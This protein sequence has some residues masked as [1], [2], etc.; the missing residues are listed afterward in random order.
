MVS[1]AGK[2]VVPKTPQ[3][4]KAVKAVVDNAVKTTACE[5]SSLV[6][7]FHRLGDEEEVFP[8][9]NII[10]ETNIRS[11]ASLRE[12]ARALG[13][14]EYNVANWSLKDL[15]EFVTTVKVFS[16][17]A[18]EIQNTEEEALTRDDI[19]ALQ[20]YASHD[21]QLWKWATQQPD[22][23]S[24]NYFPMNYHERF[25]PDV[26]SLRI[27][28]ISN[29]FDIIARVRAA[30]NARKNIYVD[31]EAHIGL[32]IKQLENPQNSYDIIV[33]DFSISGGSR[34]RG[35]YEV[36]MYV[37]NKKLDIPVVLLSKG[38]IASSHLILHNIIGQSP[39]LQSVNDAQR[40]FNYLSNIVATGKA[41]PNAKPWLQEMREKLYALDMAI[42]Q[43][44][45]RE[46][47]YTER[48]VV[49]QLLGDEAGALADREKAEELFYSTH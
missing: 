44:P 26:K 32:G 21:N 38:E 9:L 23:Y 2:T 46:E 20:L 45:M 36:G 12:E 29:D 1:R 47:L 15:E 34:G 6:S 14:P 4:E 35:G 43:E 40:F 48:A 30:Q 49:K 8:Q 19:H 10:P 25:H 33:T 28:L 24:D 7:Y 5:P 31:V 37:W 3:I 18:N 11:L 39:Y 22:F 27:L 16:N 42:R 17:V 13:M 41:Y